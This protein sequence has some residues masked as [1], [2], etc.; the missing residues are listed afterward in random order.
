M[1]YQQ[2]LKIKIGDTITQ[3][4]HGYKLLVEGISFY[5]GVWEGKS[6]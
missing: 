1:T 6:I 5:D 4:M 2:A 3:K